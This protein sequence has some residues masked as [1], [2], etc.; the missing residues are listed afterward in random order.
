LRH[1]AIRALKLRLPPSR[2]GNSSAN[3]L[4]SRGSRMCFG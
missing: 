3:A 1:D 2:Q 4:M